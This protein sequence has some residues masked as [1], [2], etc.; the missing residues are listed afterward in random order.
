V[1]EGDIDNFKLTHPED[2]VLAERTVAERQLARP[3]QAAP[4]GEPGP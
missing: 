3:R 4:R 1:V 2:L